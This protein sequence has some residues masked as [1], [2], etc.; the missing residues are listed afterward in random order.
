MVVRIAARQ[1]DLARLQA[2]EVGQALEQAQLAS[3]GPALKV[4]YSFRSSLGDQRADD[5]LW[6]MPEKG[7]FT[8]DFV[9]DLKAGVVDV[10]V[11]SW[12]DLPIG[13]RDGASIAATL[14]RAD[15]RDV[16]LVRKD[17]WSKDWASAAPTRAFR[18]LTSSPRRSH[19]LGEFL[20]WALP[21]RSAPT[22]EFVPVRGNIATRVGKL[23]TPA[24]SDDVAPDALVVAKAALDRLLT[25]SRYGESFV[26]SERHL[27]QMLQQTNFVVLPLSVNPSAAAQGALAIEVRS[28]RKDILSLCEKIDAVTDRLCVEAERAE[29]ARHGGG[30]HQKIGVTYLARSYGR[31]EFLRGL[32]DQ[33]LILDS[34]KLKREKDPLEF[35]PRPAVESEICETEMKAVN[36]QAISDFVLPRT[37]ESRPGYF[38]ARANAWPERGLDPSAAVWVA[39]LATW[40]RL[41]EKGVW[42]HGSSESLGENEATRIEMLVGSEITWTKLTHFD[43]ATEPGTLGTYRVDVVPPDAASFRGK[44]FFFWKSGSQFR[45]ALSIGPEIAK[46]YHASGPGHTHEAVIEALRLAGVSEADLKKRVAI[47]LNESDFFMELRNTK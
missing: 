20:K 46:G 16:L 24:V 9:Q 31:V 34:T 4:E 13:P 15:A 39:G 38:V 37:T 44:K 12:K 23:V 11:H 2:F 18:I 25:S 7:V 36:R 32:T 5:P 27:R 33:G 21:F 17:L 40:R 43:V 1:S 14:P 6:Q 41:S 22:I 42:V 35:W 47:F 30:C 19:N 8:Q 45:S 3:G 10:V 28:P 29:L 26:E